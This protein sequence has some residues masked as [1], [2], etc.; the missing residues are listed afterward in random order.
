MEAMMGRRTVPDSSD[1]AFV[2]G[3]IPRTLGPVSMPDAEEMLA[4]ITRH[5][6]TEIDPETVVPPDDFEDVPEGALSVAGSVASLHQTVDGLN[7]RLMVTEAT[8]T[9]LT[10]SIQALREA[11]SLNSTQILDVALKLERLGKVSS[12]I[13]ART[14]R[15]SAVKASSISVEASGIQE[16]SDSTEVMDKD[17]PQHRDSR[18][19]PR[20]PTITPVIARRRE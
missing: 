10:A 13:E 16:T 14:T 12:A 7:A 17:S 9:S 6:E 2:S 4:A 11:V 8:L 1:D 5:N 20:P 18:A 19:L 3:D 15:D